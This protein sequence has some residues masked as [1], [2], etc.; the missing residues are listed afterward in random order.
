VSAVILVGGE[1]LASAALR[2]R[3]RSAELVVAADGG[4]RH[5]R[6]LGLTPHLLVGD[7]DSVA[8]STRALHPGLTTEVHPADKDELDLELALEVV[9]RHGATEVLIVGGLT[10]RLDQTLSTV[11]IAHARHASGADVSVTDGVRDVWPLRPDETRRLD[12]ASGARFS[13]LALDEEAL[14]SVGGARYR[15]DRA[16]LA[17]ARGLGVSNVASGP[18]SV[19]LHRGAIVVV[20][21]GPDEPTRDAHLR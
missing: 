15:L 21:P 8:A 14:V 2:D 9:E 5:A 11:L 18:V 16:P 20:A 4:L 19:T 7:L 12:L 10:G 13:L 3:L 1:V 17:R 6:P